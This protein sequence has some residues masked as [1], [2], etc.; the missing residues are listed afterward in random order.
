MTIENTIS[1]Q[2]MLDASSRVALAAFLHDMGKFAERARIQ[3][4]NDKL[5]TN[6]QLYCPHRK[7]FTD[8]TGYFTHIHAA[9]TAVAM[10]LIEQQLPD[11]IGSDM[12][13]FA[14]WKSQDTDDSLINA[15]ARHHKPETFLQWVIAIA[16]R[17]ASGFERDEFENYNQAEEG[18]NHYTARQLT[19]LEQIDIQGKVK[20]KSK[21]DLKYRYS[22]KPLSPQNLFPIKAQGYE[23]ADRKQAQKEY[24][25]LWQ[26]FIQSLDKIPASHRSNLG[27]WLDHFETLWGA[28]T[29]AIPSATVGKTR[30]DVSLY[31]HSRTTAALATALWRYHHEQGATE[32]TLN[33]EWDTDKFLLIQ[34]DFFG[35]QSFIFTSGGESTKR[36]A[37]LLRG[38]SF[39]VSLLSECAAL[40]VLDALE[41]PATSQVINAAGKFLIVAP[42]TQGT[43]KKLKQVQQAL[44][45]WFLDKSWGQSGIGLAW[46]SASC[47]DFVSKPKR[48]D[49]GFKQLI[50]QLFAELETAKHQ[51]L[52]L[53]T[54]QVTP[55]FSDY[56]D[57]FDNKMGVCQI[58]GRSPARHQLEG[59]KYMGDLAKD[60]MDCGDYL[61][62]YDRLLISTDDL[63][64]HTLGLSVFGYYV[65]FTQSEEVTGKFGK[66][67]AEDNLRRVWDF[68]LPQAGDQVLWNGYAR[69][70]I[71]AYVA[72]FDET[73]EAEARLGRYDNI[74]D[75]SG[76][77]DIKTLNHLALDD[78]QLTD[79]GKK[80][81]GETG[82]MSLKGDIDNLGLM[83]QW[84][85][86]EP[87]FAKMASLS[88][89]INSF[90]AIY[91]PWLCQSEPRFRNTYTVFAG[92]DDFFLIGP[93]RSTL[94]LAKVMREK[95]AEYVAHNSQVHFSVGLSMTKP[96]L[97]IPWLAENA[98]QMLEDA[99]GY[100]PDNLD[101]PPK[102]AVSCFN[103]AMFWDEYDQLSNRADRLDELKDTLDLSTGYVYGLLKL[104]DMREKVN[105]NPQNAIW[106]SYF[107]YRTRRMLERTRGL[108]ESERRR[109]QTELARD[110]AI[111][112]IDKHAGHYRV[113]L[114][115]HLYKY[116][117]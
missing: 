46:Q 53:C 4:D 101:M 72:R 57:S 2:V 61:V 51:R 39:Y 37:K 43:I 77:G 27:L 56:L 111:D 64:H 28:Y 35:I 87:S 69:R 74:K 16:D 7:A 90:F 18:K 22:L 19:L 70:N 107:A 63:A 92:G 93:W 15:A 68:S 71:N 49:S 66:L 108:D 99:K 103:Q 42:N 31:D 84:G 97:P 117:H 81:V 83:F 41:L 67:A 78:R 110:I 48:G 96:G 44:D 32:P 62:K 36:A 3:V 94:E 24:H 30:P 21:G 55:V 76:E 8:A 113:A 38:R 100:N 1:D 9:Y 86:G 59:D 82:L 50:K 40:K 60:Q 10:D 98:E 104:V 12:F 45:S 115:T 114:F 58:D 89:Q 5:E 26:G 95:F 106:N 20:V 102:N 13:P 25:A 88:R 33:K 105:E 116:R 73:A 79:N 47:N 23:T 17:V 109:R 14:A 29:Q 91:L 75:E 52:N 65:S 112:G 80:W 11:L 6:K 34:G 85:L 54:D